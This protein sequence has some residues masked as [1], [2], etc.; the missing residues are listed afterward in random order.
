MI[1]YSPIITTMIKEKLIE[2]FFSLAIERGNGF[3]G[4]LAIGGLPPVQFDNTFASTP[5]QILTLKGVNITSR[6]SFYAITPDGYTYNDVS[7]TST[8][9]EHGHPASI[10]DV[11]QKFQAV[12][13]SGTTLMYLPKGLADAFNAA[14]DPPARYIR[15]QGAFVV[16]CDA[17]PPKFGVVIGNETLYINPKDMI[18]Q[19]RTA[20]VTGITIGGAGPYILGDVFLKNVVA[21]FD[22]GASGMRFAARGFY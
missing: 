3:G 1:P 14:F 2:P 6:Y 18:L 4:Y 10:P 16:K 11:S 9:S 19:G 5:I 7:S 8:K 15:S 21:V 12:V 22:I 20:C 17:V 13:N